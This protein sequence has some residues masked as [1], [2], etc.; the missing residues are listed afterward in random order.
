MPL[1]NL[2]IWLKFFVKSNISIIAQD[3]HLKFTIS[4]QSCITLPAIFAELFAPL[5]L[6][7][8]G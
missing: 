6:R 1:F 2:E 5:K 3:I 8:F 7:N 4:L